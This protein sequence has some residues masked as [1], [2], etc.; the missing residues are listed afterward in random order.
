MSNKGREADNLLSGALSLTISV[1]IVKIIGLIYKIPLSYVLGD[2]G[3]GYFNTAYTV[4]SFFYLLCS[5]GIPRA[6]SIIITEYKV[7]EQ[8]NNIVRIYN[9]SFKIFFVIGFALTLILLL[10][11][12]FI[13][14]KIGN[15]NSRFAMLLIAPTLL[16]VCISG[17]ARGYLNGIAS[18]V[19]ISIS[20]I[21]EGVVKFIFG[22]GFAL[23]GARINLSVPI[24]SAL[25]I[26]GVTLG[27]AISTCYLC[28]VANN[29]ISA[30]KTGQS[31]EKNINIKSFLFKLIKLITPIT[32]SSAVMGLSNVIDLGL[33]MKRLI[34]VGVGEKEAN[35]LYGN[36][37]TLVV[38]MLNLAVALITPISVAALPMLSSDYYSKERGKLS[39]TSSFLIELTAF[40][41]LPLS[42]A[43]VFFSKEILMLLYKDTSADIAAPLLTMI[44][45]A[46]LFLPLLTVINTILEAT[47]KQ[48]IPLISLGIG[49]I[50]KIFLSYYLIGDERIGITGAP[51][52]TVVS[53]GVSFLIS[54][55]FLVK[56][57]GVGL[58]IF[59]TFYKP[60][61]ISVGVLGLSKVL[62][63]KASNSVFRMD[64]FIFFVIVSTISYFVL[65][66]LGGVFSIKKLK[67]M[68]KSTKKYEFS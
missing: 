25:S 20:Q 3:M 23:L 36:Y 11:S 45:P 5:S 2:E 42:V 51:I 65:S 49:A 27:S 29:R 7:K 63:E 16:T 57:N 32:L 55:F 40:F 43:F 44:S 6:I 48:K 67:L 8:H 37:T 52:S 38:P 15:A 61:I 68:S 31:S 30:N 34:S 12:A 18:I 46:V 60:L 41:A 22:L 1:L 66:V 17:V 24:I 14:N 9:I 10:F 62:Y 28:V 56:C 33:I 4:F 19:P 50:V 21:I 53:Y 58:K 47:E 54:A 26:L 13:S 35:S 64:L 59:K 39:H